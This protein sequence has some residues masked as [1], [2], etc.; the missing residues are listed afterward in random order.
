MTA[1]QYGERTET[2]AK[3]TANPVYGVVALITFVTLPVATV[4]GVL[5]GLLLHL[6]GKI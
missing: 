4:L 2:P 3:P 6:I 1:P 5:A